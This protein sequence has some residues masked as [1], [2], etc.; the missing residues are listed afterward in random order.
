MLMQFANLYKNN[1]FNYNAI[2]ND[3]AV[4]NINSQQ[5]LRGVN[6]I[7]IHY[8]S[9][10]NGLS[11]IDFNIIDI[12]SNS[13][14]INFIWNLKGKHSSILNGILPT[15]QNIE[16][17]GMTTIYVS[18]DKINKIHEYYD[19][20]I[21][22]EQILSTPEK[23]FQ[24]TE[25]ANNLNGPAAKIYQLLMSTRKTL[26]DSKQVLVNALRQSMLSAP[27]LSLLNQEEIKNIKENTS[28][29]KEKMTLNDYDIDIHIYTPKGEEK[30]SALPTI[31]YL[32]GGG[33]CIG[34]P[35][36]YEMTNRKLA[37]T[38]HARII[39]PRYRLCP[40]HPFPAGFNDCCD[41]YLHC[42]NLPVDNKYYI[43]PMM[44]IVAGDSVGGGFSSALVLRMLNDNLPL[45]DS[46]ILLS[47]ANDM[48]LEN[49]ASYNNYT[50]NN[51]MIDQGIIGFIRGCYIQGDMWDHPYVSPI[52]GDLSRF[53]KTF[54][55][56]GEDDPLYDENIAF[57]KK[58]MDTSKHKCEVLIGAGMPHHY[59]TFI[60]L[61]DA[62]DEA[63]QKMNVFIKNVVKQCS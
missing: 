5:M 8:E 63:Y 23:I 20:K 60:G 37:L 48:R 30:N 54:I 18:N 59:H 56:I 49:Y 25:I 51:I 41:V 43:N 29:I 9:M 1:N 46:L 58:L 50:R 4:L 44:I 10:K 57:A 45:P 21:V 12:H 31:L 14:I 7:K 2:F 61:A 6:N 38:T 53:P 52:R 62:V 39:C 26:T 28:Q 55:M 36:Q 27:D 35:E 15:N 34:S 3:D 19:S 33:W 47:P 16:Y 22:D 13:D 32:H 24:H 11:E 40:E 42:R 17:K